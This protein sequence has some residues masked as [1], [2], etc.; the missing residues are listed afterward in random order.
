M[1]DYERGEVQ[2]RFADIIWAN[3]PVSSGELVRLC[4][5]E[6][7]WKKST[8]YTVL[9]KLCEKGIFA[10]RDGEVRSLMSREEFYSRRSELFVQESFGGSLPAFIAAFTSGRRLSAEDAAQIRRMIEEYEQQEE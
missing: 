8:T 4:E 7:G 1:A 9:R 10:N 2:S 3:E 6:L 5:A